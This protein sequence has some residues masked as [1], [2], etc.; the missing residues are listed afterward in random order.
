MPNQHREKDTSLLEPEHA[1]TAEDINMRIARLKREVA[2]GTKVYT[3][4]ELN[5]LQS[6]LNDYL[7]ILKTLQN[8]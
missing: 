7:A 3:P 6:K 2:R 5:K 1:P 4:E 8:P